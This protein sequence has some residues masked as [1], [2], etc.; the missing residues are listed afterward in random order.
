MNYLFWNIRGIGKGEKSISIRNL[1]EKKNISFMGV[2]ETKHRRSIRES[3][4][5]DVG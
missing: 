4:E 3:D 2:V 1:V 5:E